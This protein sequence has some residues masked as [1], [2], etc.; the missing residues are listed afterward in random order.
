MQKRGATQGRPTRTTS[1]GPPGGEGREGTKHSTRF[2]G[3]G[4][5][6]VAAHHVEDPQVLKDLTT[7]AKS[8]L[9]KVSEVNRQLHAALIKKKLLAEELRKSTR[10]LEVR[11]ET[12]SQVML[13]ARRKAVEELELIIKNEQ[14]KQQT[15]SLDLGR[16]IMEREELVAELTAINSRLREAGLKNRAQ[17]K[18]LQEKLREKQGQVRDMERH[19]QIMEGADTPVLRAGDSISLLSFE[20]SEAS[21]SVDG[22]DGGDREQRSGGLPGSP[23]GLKTIEELNE[24]PGL[25][26]DVLL[27][28]KPPSPTQRR[29]TK[30]ALQAAG[31]VPSSSKPSKQPGSRKSSHLA[32]A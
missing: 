9:S 20:G 3:G 32:P 31:K 16:E 24:L 25:D 6:E 15:D 30:K 29:M 23:G 10:D 4:S 27:G 5:L 21:Q 19:V 13:L 12:D 14:R 2:A 8:R 17:I 26:L 28:N 18:D 11:I 22:G 7:A 1:T